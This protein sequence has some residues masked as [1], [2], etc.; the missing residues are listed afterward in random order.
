MSLSIQINKEEDS[1]RFSNSPS[2][3]LNE[4]KRTKL[5]KEEKKYKLNLQYIYCQH[6]QF[7]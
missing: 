4:K 2:I 3:P 5:K 6:S 1:V 7:F